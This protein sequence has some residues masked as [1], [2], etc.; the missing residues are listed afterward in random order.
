MTARVEAASERQLVGSALTGTTNDAPGS[1][2][3]ATQGPELLDYSKSSS[4]WSV[5]THTS[6]LPHTILATCSALSLPRYMTV[7]T[8]L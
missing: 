1:R 8:S 7:A 2:A 4:D 5:P 6:H 3:R